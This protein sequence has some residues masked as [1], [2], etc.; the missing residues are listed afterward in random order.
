MMKSLTV[1]LGVGTPQSD[2]PKVM[3]NSL[4]ID[5]YK[6]FTSDNVIKEEDELDEFPKVLGSETS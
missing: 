4:V 5:D 6:T 2:T 3:Q 1:D